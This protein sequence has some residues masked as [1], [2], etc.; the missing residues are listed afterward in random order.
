ML[1]RS[2]DQAAQQASGFRERSAILEESLRRE[3]ARAS[4]LEAAQ[5]ALSDSAGRSLGDNE[6]MAA[7]LAAT[8]REIAETMRVVEESAEALR[9]ARSE[10]DSALALLRSS[11]VAVVELQALE[12]R[13]EEK[14]REI[15][16]LR[17]ALLTA[18]ASGRPAEPDISP[19]TPIAM[20][21]PV[22]PPEPIVPIAP[23]IP[24]RPPTPVVALLDLERSSYEELAAVEEIGPTR[25]RALGWFRDNIQIGR[26]HHLKPVTC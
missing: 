1:F 22:V 10:R 5:A 15:A 11:G 14:E 19:S 21:E 24:V 2:R 18:P 9:R 16:A 17:A 7:E 20:V 25:A 13:I 12:R 26:V 3:T 23:P 6:R 4:A 8:R